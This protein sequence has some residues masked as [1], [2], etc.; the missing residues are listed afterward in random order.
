MNWMIAK[1]HILKKT[2][3]PKRKMFLTKKI[4]SKQEIS[5]FLANISQKIFK[6]TIMVRMEKTWS[7][8]IM[9]L[10]CKKIWIQKFNTNNMSNDAHVLL[11]RLELLDNFNVFPNYSRIKKKI[12]RYKGKRRLASDWHYCSFRH[13]NQ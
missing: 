8:L 9:I 1:S 11:R 13:C 6:L 12:L 3:F 5:T 7:I 10:K 2:V 4:N